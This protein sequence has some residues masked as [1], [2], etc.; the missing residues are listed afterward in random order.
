MAEREIPVIEVV[1]N[2]ANVLVFWCPFCFREHHHGGGEAF[3]KGDGHRAAHCGPDSP[4]A[5]TGYVLKE[6]K[7]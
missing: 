3:G 2:E 4:Y 1:R 5:E 6:V 7:A